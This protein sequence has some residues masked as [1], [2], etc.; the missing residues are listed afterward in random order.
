MVQV[1]REDKK[2][3]VAKFG[4]KPIR[5]DRWAVIEDK[6]PPII[7]PRNELVTRL[8]TNQC[9]LC[10]SNENINVHHIRKLKDLNRR[11]QGRKAPPKWAIKMMA[12]RRKTLV[13]CSACHQAIH[14]GTYDGPKLK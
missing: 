1:P 8:L 12:I 3:L 4:A 5:F 13:V 10:G 11:Y 6:K 9:E 2:P 14:A 7:T